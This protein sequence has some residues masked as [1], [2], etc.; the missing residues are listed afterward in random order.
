[1][2]PLPTARTR[3]GSCGGPRSPR[4]RSPGSERLCGCP[5][6]TGG[7]G[8]AGSVTLLRQGRGPEGQC[9]DI[10]AGRAQPAVPAGDEGRGE[11]PREGTAVAERRLA[12]LFRQL[13]LL[14]LRLL[15]NHFS[16]SQTCPAGKFSP[17]GGFSP[18]QPLR[19]LLARWFAE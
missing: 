8:G 11:P 15:G 16:R 14:L 4:P 9:G 7:F 1:M 5:R 12:Q 13:F 18:W 6:D 17:H 2:E 10:P 19:G 3:V